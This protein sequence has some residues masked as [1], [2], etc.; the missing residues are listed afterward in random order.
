MSYLKP[1]GS[2]QPIEPVPASKK[3]V[4]DEKPSLSKSV[5][6]MK[7]MSKKVTED[8]ETV[9]DLANAIYNPL[10]REN[11]DENKNIRWE[12]DTSQIT[13]P[14]RR[15]FGGC[16]KFVERN[17][18]KVL[19]DQYNIKLSERE[20]KATISEEE[21]IKRYDELVSL[22]RGPN[23]GLRKP[24][25]SNGGNN[26][27]RKIKNSQYPSAQ[28]KSKKKRNRDETDSV[29]MVLVDHVS[30]KKAKKSAI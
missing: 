7:F 1:K 9:S 3:A 4:N 21:M 11:L 28:E 17:Y 12:R 6:S 15:S 14:G 19:E 5:L 16:N 18:A 27:D 10:R 30:S 29:P 24:R 8:T 13:F 23:Q 22:P 20:D 2:L 26:I 25:P